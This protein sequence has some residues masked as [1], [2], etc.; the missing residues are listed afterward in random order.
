MLRYDYEEFLKALGQRVRRL[1]EERGISHRVLTRDHGFHLNQV[2][3]I[4]RGEGLSI[5]TLL[6]VCETFQVR[7]EDLLAG[8]GPETAEVPE[9][10]S[11]H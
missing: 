7:I 9:K 5:P 2:H 6:R 4:E 11:K 10:P 1:R 8:I 3:R